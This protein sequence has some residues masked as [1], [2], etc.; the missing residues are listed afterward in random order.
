MK[1]YSVSCSSLKRNIRTSI[2]LGLMLVMG[3]PQNVSAKSIS[4]TQMKKYFTSVYSK[5]KKYDSSIKTLP[6]TGRERQ[7][8]GKILKALQTDGKK[9]QSLVK[10]EKSSQA[11]KD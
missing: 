2:L 9:I 8:S 5:A 3:L 4:S 10:V 11:Q 1:F 7:L 6:K